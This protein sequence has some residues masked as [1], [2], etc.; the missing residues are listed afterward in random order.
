MKVSQAASKARSI[1]KEKKGEVFDFLL[2]EIIVRLIVLTPFLFLLTDNLKL[3]SLLSIPLFLLIVPFVREKAAVC[4]QSALRGGNLFS[5]DLLAPHGY[6][7]AVGHGLVQALLLILWAAPFLGVT[8]W[9]YRIIFGETVVG[10]TDVF[11]VILAVT[12]LGGGDMVRGAAYAFLLYLCTLLPF[13]VG[14][15]F[16]SGTRHARACGDKG[17][18]K[19]HRGGIIQAW[20]R[21]LLT[22]V[23][24]VAVSA[25]AGAD[26]LKKLL[27]AVNQLTGNGLSIPRPDS[28]LYIILGAFVL[29]LLPL[30]PLKSL[31][32]AAYV[33]GLQE[34]RT[35]GEA[36]A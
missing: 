4:M 19:G 36:K 35:S 11:S 26:Y 16:H 21:S 7:K 5:R 15:A 23:P 8:A 27:E 3:L 25:W 12:E 2:L 20:L 9:L 10:Q 24:F 31:I 13:C 33:G 30:L 28:G 18:V 6:W 29:L 1:Y 34:E 17:L 22:L 32:S 14:L